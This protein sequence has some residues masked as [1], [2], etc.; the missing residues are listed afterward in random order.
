MRTSGLVWAAIAVLASGCAAK[1]VVERFAADKTIAEVGTSVTL[2]WRV[3]D[4]DSVS[5]SNVGP[6]PAGATFITL[7]PSQTTT[8][9]LSAT[10]EGGT[11]DSAPLTVTVNPRLDV[12]GGTYAS[13]GALGRTFA[14]V[15]RELSNQPPTSST[16]VSITPPGGTAFNL[17]CAGGRPMCVVLEPNVAPVNGSYTAG[18]TVGGVPVTHAFTVD[19]ADRMY[20]A[21]PIFAEQTSGTSVSASWG[22]SPGAVTY[23]ARLVDSVGAPLG[24]EQVLTATEAVLQSSTALG[25]SVRVAIETAAVD[26]TGNSAG[27][28]A[29]P[30]PNVTVADA[31]L[32]GKPGSWQLFQPG[33]FQGNSL[34]VSLPSLA[35]GERAAVIVLNI[36]GADFL[37][38]APANNV[39]LAITGTNSLP[40]RDPGPVWEKAGPEQLADQEGRTAHQL[41]RA[42]DEA[43]VNAVLAKAGVSAVRSAAPAAAPTNASFCVREGLSSR[44]SRRTATLR[45]E[46]AHMVFYVDDA[47]LTDFSTHEPG[48]WTSLGQSWEGSANN[49]I[50]AKVTGAFGPESDV[51]ADGK[52]LVLFSD[53]LGPVENGGILL[54]YFSSGDTLFTRDETATCAG[55]AGNGADMFIMNGIK[56]LTDAGNGAADVINR[57]YP[58][59]LAHEFQHLINTNG[60]CLLNDCTLLEEAW[61][62]EGLSMVAEDVAGFGWN[63]NTLAG[64]LYLDRLPG[65]NQFSYNRRSVTTWEG[66]PLG[67]YQAVHS[68]VRYWADRYG[69]GILPDLVAGNLRGAERTEAVLLAPF[70]R[71]LAEWT[72]ALMFSNESFSP[73]PVFN[74]T[75]A[76]W[77]PF[78]SAL[79]YVNYVP[80]NPGSGV[81]AAVR[82]NGWNAFVTGT[83]GGGNATL[84]VTSTETVKP[85]VVVVRFAGYLQQCQGLPSTVISGQ[86]P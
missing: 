22:P 7:N 6:I 47:D 79:T 27:P 51:D 46:T 80:L 19:S 38:T 12:S 37:P 86:C 83:G 58:D 42:L 63:T 73:S 69:Q 56:N 30:A 29:P 16:T 25:A 3:I 28:Q 10:N 31:P 53:L 77:T 57:V 13:P 5:I 2:Q 85:H 33:S 48:I 59:T 67:N 62:N 45:H 17:E 32:G 41:F 82:R 4:A 84:T 35:L 43:R 49:G 39:Q 78:H 76:A 66:D 61:L 18:A 44:F 50:Y 70:S 20:A 36:D 11:V 68:L 55:T 26:L 81:S 65:P 64:E 24:P 75:G 8:Y 15:L 40:L 23:R 21:G 52:L 71:Q 34:T 14:V 72:T 60:H 74:F 1:P 9:V 54:G